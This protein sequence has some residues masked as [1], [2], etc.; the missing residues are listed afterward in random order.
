LIPNWQVYCVVFELPSRRRVTAIWNADGQPVRVRL[1]RAAA[2]AR[3]LDQQ[4]EPL[5]PTRAAAD[6]QID[7]PAATAHYAGDPPGYYFIG[8]D[9]RLLIEDDVPPSTP[10]SPPRLS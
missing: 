1:P 6:W 2:T 10:V 8:G 7:L 4:G 9:P 5:T 3:L